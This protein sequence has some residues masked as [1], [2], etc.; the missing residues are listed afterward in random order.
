MA[1][2][3][4]AALGSLDGGRYRL[5]VF[6]T[7]R[8]DAVLDVGCARPPAPPTTAVL[9]LAGTGGMAPVDV[10]RDTQPPVQLVALHPDAPPGP[11][12]VPLALLCG[13]VLSVFMVGWSFLRR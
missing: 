6:G 10:A 12:P 13:L 2:V 7:L 5:Q 9:P 8:L 4:A 11:S 1:A 3:L